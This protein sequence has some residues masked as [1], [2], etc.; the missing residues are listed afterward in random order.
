[1]KSSSIFL[2]LI[3]FFFFQ[4]GLTAQESLAAQAPKATLKITGTGEIKLAP[5][6][7]VVNMTVKTTDPYFNKAVQQLNEK[8]D[9]LNKKLLAAGFRREEIKTSQL[10]VQ[11]NGEWRD[12]NYINKGFVA[13]QSIELRFKRDQ[14]RMSKLMETFSEEKGA[15]ALFHFGFTLSDQARQ[16]AEEELIRKAIQDSRNKAAVIAKTSGVKLGKIRN[17]IYGQPDMRPMPMYEAAM[18][19]QSMRSGKSQGM[20]DIEVQEIQMQDTITIY[21]DIE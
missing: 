21:W 1:M 7:A 18:M 15:E 12:G 8:T 17:I 2:L 14:Q 11:E 9:R 13:T 20:P 4:D 3:I 16:Q 19:D 10:N 5:D 6:L